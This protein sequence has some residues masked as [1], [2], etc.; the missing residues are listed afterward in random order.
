MV[1]FH[2]YVNVYQRVSLISHEFAIV[3]PWICPNTISLL[4]HYNL[5]SM[6]Q[7]A[8]LLLLLLL[9]YIIIIIVIITI[10]IVATIY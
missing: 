10:I 2:S 9:L 5:I 6:L 8:I 4:S 1:I 3:I 7:Y